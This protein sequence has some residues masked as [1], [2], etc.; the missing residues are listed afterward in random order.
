[1][2]EFGM[3]DS[4]QVRFL[5]DTLDSEP[6]VLLPHAIGLVTYAAFLL[7]KVDRHP[8]GRRVLRSCLSWCIESGHEDEHG[9]TLLTSTDGSRESRD[10][11]DYEL[12]RQPFLGCKHVEIAGYNIYR[13]ATAGR[14]F[15]DQQCLGP[16]CDAHR[17]QRGLGRHVLRCRD[18][19]DFRRTI[20]DREALS[21]R[22][23]NTPRSGVGLLIS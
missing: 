17:Q 15:Q 13:G 6:Q 8:F 16:R 19:G 12:Q 3:W 4:R 10:S 22:A 18:G 1:M 11:F 21:C 23:A 5:L 20:S 14:V 2:L 9:P 7:T